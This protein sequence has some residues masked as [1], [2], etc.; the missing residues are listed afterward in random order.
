MYNKH[1]YLI[2]PNGWIDDLR[3]TSFSKVFQS[4]DDVRMIMKGYVQ[5]YSIQLVLHVICIS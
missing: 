2:Y 5:L 4:Y 3:F 1:I